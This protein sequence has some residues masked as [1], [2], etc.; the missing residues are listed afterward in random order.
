MIGLLSSACVDLIDLRRKTKNSTR[1]IIKEPPSPT[2]TPTPI[3][4]PSDS[5]LFPW[6]VLL[7]LVVV[8]T[9]WLEIEEGLKL[10]VEGIAVVVDVVRLAA[11]R[12]DELGSVMLK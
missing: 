9:A 1:A 3:L 10:C 5:P 2:A 12:V 7:A 8:A 6:R 4:A 11:V